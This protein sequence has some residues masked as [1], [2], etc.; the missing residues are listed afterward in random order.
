MPAAHSK[1]AKRHN[2][3]KWNQ[4]DRRIRQEAMRPAGIGLV[5]AAHA[6]GL[7]RLGAWLRGETAAG[8]D[9]NL[10]TA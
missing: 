8:V 10:T 2:R 5:A 1:R 6:F 7:V 4:V 3:R 9:E